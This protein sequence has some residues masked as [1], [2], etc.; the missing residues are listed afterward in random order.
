MRWQDLKDDLAELDKTRERWFAEYP[1][2]SVRREDNAIEAAA[3]RVLALWQPC[4]D[5]GCALWVQKPGYTTPCRRCHGG[6]IPTE[7][8]ES[9]MFGDA[10]DGVFFAW[11][12]LA[13]YLFGEGD[14]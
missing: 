7:R 3:R 1:N 13:V 2:S 5:C 10:E 9:M 12:E 6:I 11:N 8:L 14:R 4:P